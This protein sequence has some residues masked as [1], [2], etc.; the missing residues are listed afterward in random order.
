MSPAAGEL[1]NQV[2]RAE[3]DPI[4]QIGPGARPG[5]LR[6]G[7]FSEITRDSFRWQGEAS[8]DESRTRR[9]VQEMPATRRS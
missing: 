8:E 3:G 1:A 6:R 7:T 4:I 5:S 2:G 9:L